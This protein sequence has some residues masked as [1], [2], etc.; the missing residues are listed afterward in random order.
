LTYKS[1]EWLDEDSL[2]ALF[3]II[4]CTLK[5]YCGLSQYKAIGYT[6][7]A[8]IGRLSHWLPNH[9]PIALVDVPLRWQNLR[10]GKDLVNFQ[11]IRLIAAEV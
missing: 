1:T 3:D 5:V 11:G 10:V 8:G 6:E 4:T 9:L 2:L 7:P